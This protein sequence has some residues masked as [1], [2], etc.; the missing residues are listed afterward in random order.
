MELLNIFLIAVIGY[1]VGSLTIKGIELGTAGVLLAALVFGHYGVTVPAFVNDLGIALFVTSVGFI[2]GPKFFRNLKGNA[3]SY[4][5]LGA[6]V[7]LSG[8]AA[9]TAV[10]ILGGVPTSLATG[11]FAGA[12]TSTPGLAAAAEAFSGADSQLVAV[13]YGLAYPFGVVGVV[14]FVQIIPKLLKV[15][16]TEER[17]NIASAPAA[18]KKVTPGKLFACDSLG[19]MPFC[20]AVVLGVIIGRISVPLPGGAQFALGAAGGPLISGL[21]FGHVAHIGRM[22][23]KV[24]DHVLEVFRE[25]GL[26]LF[27]IAAGTNGGRGFVAVLAEHGGMLFVY[28][29]IITMIPLLAGFLFAGRVLKMHLL[30][31]IGSICGGITSTPALG[32]LIKVSGTNDIAAAYAATY[33]IALVLVVLSAQFMAIL[34]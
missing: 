7:V 12:L 21:V 15:N 6:V 33:P 29:A 1:L 30:N 10:I 14:L 11:L 22:S 32:T 20:T 23:L 18:A 3:S 17:N 27:L 25:F 24:K 31:N 19:L 34:L 26:V 28:G 9:C 16:M 2:A 5:M 4:A 13:G 8:A